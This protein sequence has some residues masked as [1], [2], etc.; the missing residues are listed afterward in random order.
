MVFHYTDLLFFETKVPHLYVTVKPTVVKVT[1]IRTSRDVVPSDLDAESVVTKLTT[2]CGGESPKSITPWRVCVGQ[3]E[4]QKHLLFQIYH[5]VEDQLALSDTTDP[6][7]VYVEEEAG[8]YSADNPI[9]ENHV[10]A[11]HE[12]YHT[13]RR[14]FLTT[15]TFK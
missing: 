6:F 8:S 9:D 4:N 2:E 15:H 7:D 10:G 14:N 3:N 11:E 12:G 5:K 13:V 1:V